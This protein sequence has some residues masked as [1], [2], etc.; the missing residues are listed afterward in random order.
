AD[1]LGSLEAG[2]DATL[3]VTTGDPLDI[4][5]RV[6]N[7]YIQGRKVDLNDRQKTLWKKYQEKYRQLKVQD[8]D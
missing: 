4:R 2:K 5:S 6:T 1:R 3:I 8:E 7:A